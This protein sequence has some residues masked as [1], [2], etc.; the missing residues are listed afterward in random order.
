MGD[1]AWA[2]ACSVDLLPLAANIKAIFLHHL[3]DVGQI[4]AP[5]RAD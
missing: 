3:V 2:T 5:H 1:L 4:Q